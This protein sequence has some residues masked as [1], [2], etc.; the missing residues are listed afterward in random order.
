MAQIVAPISTTTVDNWNGNSNG[1]NLHLDISETIALT[2]DATSYISIESTLLGQCT[3]K[4]KLGSLN[5]PIVH[6]G[7]ILRVRHRK[8]NALGNDFFDISL[9]Q[10]NTLI[11]TESIT[12]SGTYQTSTIT[13][14]EAEAA[15]ITNY[16]DLYV[17]IGYFSDSNSSPRISTVEF[18][19][20]GDAGGGATSSNP[21]IYGS[22]VRIVYGNY[23]VDIFQMQFQPTC[24]IG[25]ETGT[26]AFNTG[27]PQ[28]YVIDWGDGTITRNPDNQ[29]LYSTPTLK[30]VKIYGKINGLLYSD[31][32]DLDRTSVTQIT[33]W[34]GLRIRNNGTFSGCT[35]LF[36][37]SDS[38]NQP[39]FT[40]IGHPTHLFTQCNLTTCSIGHW[41]F[42]S[43]LTGMESWFEGSPYFNDNISG[44]NTENIKDMAKMFYNADNFNQPIGYWDVSNVVDMANMF[45]NANNFNQPL[46]GWNTSKVTRILGMFKGATAFNQNINNWNITGVTSLAETFRTANNF[47]QP[48]SGWDT[49]RV[50]TLNS[51]FLGAGSFNQNINNWNT[52]SVTSMN[53]CFSGATVFNQPLS[54][55]DTSSVTNM[56]N[57]F[58]NATQFNQNIDSWNTNSN[59]TMFS[60]FRNVTGFSQSLS[61][62]NTSNVTTIAQCFNGCSI[63]NGNITGWNTNSCTLM[64][65][66]FQN[67]SGF[68]RDISNWNTSNVTSMASMLFNCTGFNQPIGKWNTSQVTSI[69]NML[70]NADSFN[71]DL[72]NWTVTGITAAGSFMANA[73]G[74]ST[75]NYDRTLSGWAQQSGNVQSGVSIHFGGSKYSIATGQQYRN[76]LI[77]KGWTF[78]DGGSV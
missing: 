75:F 41:R 78:T 9:Y 8:G 4:V 21:S 48:L 20:P 53:S 64:N 38:D 30:T 60:M 5:D 26:I 47:N 63:F 28:K 15:N 52:S 45:E 40:Y 39:D 25:C 43:N 14:L 54:G 22:G 49:S 74:L 59:T 3:C 34:G 18:E 44:W 42:P 36:T 1:S 71:Q 23:P 55:W 73:S 35:D 76:I 70:N 66:A 24:D 13:L 46:S 31:A 12:T 37:I 77:A 50:V 67:A 11:R 65:S 58:Y 62:W 17:T 16:T 51:T 27:Y 68:N 33:K 29:H 6:T 2:D 7:H 72:S 61:G 32:V 10:D 19:T 56:A 57:M 69:A